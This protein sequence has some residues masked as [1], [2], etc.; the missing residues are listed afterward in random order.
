MDTSHWNFFISQKH[1]TV[2]IEKTKKI[3]NKM[4]FFLRYENCLKSG[5]K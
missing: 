1:N 3:I 5:L 2:H 4:F